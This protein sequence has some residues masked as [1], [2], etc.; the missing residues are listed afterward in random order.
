MKLLI[1]IDTNT[2]IALRIRA[3]NEDK[4]MQR[5][6]EDILRDK[7]VIEPGAFVCHQTVG[8]EQ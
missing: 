2:E 1:N 4:K 5:V 7:L 3:A 6:A 8:E